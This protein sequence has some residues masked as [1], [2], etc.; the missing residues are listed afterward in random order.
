MRATV[1]A[2]TAGLALVAAPVAAAGPAAGPAA[3][4]IRS[5]TLLAVTIDDLPAHGPL[6]PGATRAGVVRAIVAALRARR[7]PA[8][9]FFNAGF[10]RSEPGHDEAVAA[11]RGSGLPLG[12]HGRDHLGL[13]DAGA[14][15]FLA[16]L[17]RNEAPLAAA[18][19]PGSDRRWFRY[20]F[21]NEGTDA[22]TR[23]AVRAGLRARGYRIAAVSM[24]FAD[25]DW[26]AAWAG[27]ARDRAAA[28][29]L[30]RGFLA[31]ARTAA[32]SAVEA[33]GP[34]TPQVLLLHAGAMDAAVLPR[35]LALYRAMG[36]RFGTLA[37]AEAHSR[38]AAATDL[39][40]P[41][42]TPPPPA[43]RLAG[44]PPLPCAAQPGARP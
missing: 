16:D 14:A 33:A 20:P 35:L 39:S 3:A 42:P 17:D 34:G 23:A 30:E 38:Y 5:G 40:L 26:Q 36:F 9:G 13:D 27:C 15:A 1:A 8:T 18:A 37:E 11:W 44:P 10:G 6:P 19:P 7:V 22:A 2:W 25:Y 21:L 32:L 41:G 31:D 12:S 29:R 24:S 43:V 4:R 28:R